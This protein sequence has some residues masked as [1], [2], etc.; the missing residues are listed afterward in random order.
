MLVPILSSFIKHEAISKIVISLLCKIKKPPKLWQESY[1]F[2]YQVH[3][4]CK[5]NK[6]NLE[7]EIS[8][9]AIGPQLWEFVSADNTIRK[10]V[11]KDLDAL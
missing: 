10:A 2:H 11:M 4:S 5:Q 9:T 3:F 7:L 1:A 6:M 8:Q